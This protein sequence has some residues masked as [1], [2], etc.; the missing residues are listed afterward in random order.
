M[1]GASLIDTVCPLALGGGHCLCSSCLLRIPSPLETN[2][3]D[4]IIFVPFVFL[5]LSGGNFTEDN[6][7]GWELY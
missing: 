7:F 4:T 2:G 3:K 1:A 6:G 5:F